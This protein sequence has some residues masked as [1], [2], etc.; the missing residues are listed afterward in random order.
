MDIH[1]KR[2][3]NMQLL[4]R[5]TTVIC[6]ALVLNLSGT[7]LCFAIEDAIIAVVNDELITL[8][9]LKD[10]V[11]STYVSLVAE[12]MEEAQ[13]Q[14]VM[15]DME[16]NGI[17]KLIEDK[18]I[19][20]KANI[21]GLVVREELVDER[22][23]NVEQRYGSQQNL[24]NALMKNGSTLTDLK[25]KIKDQ[26][27]IKYVIDHEVR[28]KIYVN[29]QEVTDYYEKNRDNFSREDRINL[30]SIYMAFGND[31]ATTRT[32]A[33]EILKKIKA[34]EN[35]DV[36][37]EKYSETPSVGTVERGQFLPSIENIVFGLRIN[38]ISPAVETDTGIYIFKLIGNS[39][40]KIAELEDVKDSIYD[41]LFKEKFKTRFMRWLEK[42][43]E[44]AYIEIKE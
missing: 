10:Y 7:S 30:D 29:P 6:M 16:V 15:K 36:L 44:D 1:N 12:G 33:D 3:N 2:K 42:L 26:Q 31:K 4:M 38:D 5:W 18:L 41:L 14:A 17:N 22:V 25:N 37:M 21:I 39:P 13:L 27:K 20:S 9:D 19:L 35:F 11:R 28:S 43:K 24:I 32:K 40:A 34:G 23:E 8:K